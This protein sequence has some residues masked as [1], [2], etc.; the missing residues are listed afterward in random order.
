[1]RKKVTQGYMIYP[2]W[3]DHDTA[4][5]L[6]LYANYRY[7]RYNGRPANSTVDYLKELMGVETKKERVVRVELL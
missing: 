2:L 7:E 5:S 3:Q 1:M 6:V 4:T